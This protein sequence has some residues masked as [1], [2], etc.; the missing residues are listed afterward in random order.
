MKN[1]KNTIRILTVLFLTGKL[2]TGQIS[3]DLVGTIMNGSQ[4]QFIKINPN[5]GFIS[6]VGNQTTPIFGSSFINIGNAAFDCSNDNYVFGCNYNNQDVLLT[7]SKATGSIISSYGYPIIGL[8]YNQNNGLHYGLEYV[9]F[10]PIAYKL[11]SFDPVNGNKTTISSSTISGISNGLDYRGGFTL[12]LNSNKYIFLY[13][14]GTSSPKQKILSIDI[15]NGAVNTATVNNQYFLM[16]LAH[17][18]NNAITYSYSY[19]SVD[20]VFFNTVTANGTVNK[21]SSI[22]YQFYSFPNGANNPSSGFALNTISGVF[23]YVSINNKL[24]NININTG[25]VISNPSLSSA[26]AVSYIQYANCNAVGLNELSDEKQGVFFYPNPTTEKTLFIDK[27]IIDG[28]HATINIINSL[29]Q[30][31][32]SNNVTNNQIDQKLDLSFIPDGHYIVEYA[33]KKKRHYNSLILK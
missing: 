31:L 3:G 24:T 28:E 12:D 4:T 9:S 13:N 22:S 33:D 27:S 10:S 19:N 23:T 1:K 14:T 11:V 2:M 30:I 21:L 8:T 5:T 20:S 18:N 7:I 25:A 29:G 6:T 15:I 16:G 17:N 26:D 32:Y